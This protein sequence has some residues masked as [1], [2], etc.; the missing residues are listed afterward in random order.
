MF[1]RPTT[2]GMMRRINFPTRVASHLFRLGQ[3]IRDGDYL[4]HFRETLEDGTTRIPDSSTRSS[5]A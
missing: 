5:C 2:T 3:R 4:P 1:V